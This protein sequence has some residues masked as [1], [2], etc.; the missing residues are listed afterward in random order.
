MASVPVNSDIWIKVKGIKDERQYLADCISE[1]ICP[2][3]GAWLINDKEKPAEKL[4]CLKCVDCDFTIDD[5]AN[6]MPQM[7]SSRVVE[8]KYEEAT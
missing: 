4:V 8:K 3:C 7:P 2:K 6:S 1:R 5:V